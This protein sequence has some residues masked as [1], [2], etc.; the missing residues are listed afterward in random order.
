MNKIF[1][2][3]PWAA[4]SN[5]YE[6]NIRQYTPEGTFTAFSEHL[7]RLKDMGVEIIWLM[8][9]T[10]I[11]KKG[12][13]GSLGSYYACSSYT[14]VNPEFGNYD[15]FRKL[16]QQTHALGMKLIIDWVANHTGLDHHWTK[17][18]PDW[19]IRDAAGNFTERNGWKDVIDLDY[20]NKL[21]RAELIK[22]MQFWVTEFEIDGFRCDMA[23]L[24]PLDF[25]QEAREKCDQLKPLF[26]LAECEVPSYHD[27][28]DAS[29][30]WHW[31]HVSEQ[32]SR[33][34]KTLHDI[35]EVLHSYSQYPDGALKLF[36]TTNHDENS[37]NGT[38]Y[39]KYGK[40]TNAW[41][42]F[43]ATWKGLPLIYSGQ[44]IPNFKR[45]LF[46]DK[47]TIGWEKPLQLHSF[48][49][50]LLAL[51]KNNPALIT[52]ETFILPTENSEAIMAY[53]R[54]SGE[55][56]VLVLLNLSQNEKCKVA[57]KHEWLSGKYQS[58]FS[59]MNYS[60]AS[61]ENFELLPGEYLLYESI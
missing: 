15:D 25:W 26:W 13:L 57:V 44:E 61:E 18:H 59:G 7:P 49:Q 2:T 40:A 24:V 8:P 56:I 41:A 29:Y 50:T 4:G 9:V 48:Y 36:F 43:S 23:H 33:G 32:Q 54:R 10:P 42:V 60:F 3:V 52:G 17:E 14:S 55:R 58:V 1:S 47:D 12:R 21:M 30:A 11:S 39:E 22:A 28:F 37:W 6:V 51:R 53:L 31:M 34:E 45:I 38:E 16:V 35:R 5:I 46:F 20:S 27:V 19:Y